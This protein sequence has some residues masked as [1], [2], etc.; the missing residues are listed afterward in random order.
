MRTVELI[1]LILL[2]LVYW[3]F[4][5]ADHPRATFIPMH[6]YNTQLM[7][8]VICMTHHHLP[9]IH[10]RSDSPSSSLVWYVIETVHQVSGCRLRFRYNLGSGEQMVSLS[11]VNVSDGVWHTANVQRVGQWTELRLDGGEGRYYNETFGVSG[12]HLEI[13]ISQRNM[14]AGGD[15][16]FP[17]SNSPR[18]QASKRTP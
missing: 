1:L 16:R 4:S 9:I 7:G 13:R 14:F 5:S 6:I 8:V 10:C 3:F 17:S 15:V 11:H 18:K 12:G 2:S